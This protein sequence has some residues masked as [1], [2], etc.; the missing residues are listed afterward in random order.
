MPDRTQREQGGE[1]SWARS[2]G[3]NQA[4]ASR[5]FYLQGTECVVAGDSVSA[6]EFCGGHRALAGWL[7]FKDFKWNVAGRDEESGFGAAHSGIMTSHPQEGDQAYK[8]RE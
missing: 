6:E 1:S 8:P 7:E 5:L 4:A 3:E 2:Y